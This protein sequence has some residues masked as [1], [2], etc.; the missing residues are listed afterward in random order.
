MVQAPGP[1]GRLVVEAGADAAP[2]LSVTGLGT[3]ARPGSVL[4]CGGCRRRAVRLR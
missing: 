1:E 4:S 2:S 3:C